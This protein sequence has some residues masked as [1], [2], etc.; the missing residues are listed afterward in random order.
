MSYDILRESVPIL[1]RRK[2]DMVVSGPN[3]ASIIIG[4]DRVGA[5]DSGYG[6]RPGAGAI[7]I[8]V[9]RQGEDPSLQSDGAAVYI[10][11]KCDP[12]DA[13]DIDQGSNERGVST[14]VLRGDSLRLSA[15]KD[16]K[17]SVGS[18]WI[19]IRQDGT[20]ILDGDIQLGEGTTEHLVRESFVNSTFA[21]H[22]HPHPLGPTGPTAM[23]APPTVFTSKSRG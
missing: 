21:A 8:V 17:I 7:H 10:S 19:H 1:K 13:L 6:D 23:L 16:L 12:D 18:A 2:G 5:V 20:I 11:A 14:V 9:G 4:R 22:T 3:N 15:R